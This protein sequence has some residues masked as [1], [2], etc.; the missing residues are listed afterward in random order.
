M[1]AATTG[2]SDAA[3]ALR[4]ATKASGAIVKVDPESF[5]SILQ[6]QE[7]P[8]VVTTKIIWVPDF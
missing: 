5:M 7:R 4:Q 8:E 1:N 2:A 3:V 6:R